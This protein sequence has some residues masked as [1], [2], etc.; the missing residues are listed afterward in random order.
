MYSTSPHTFVSA[1]TDAIRTL[2][3]QVLRLQHSQIM[4]IRSLLFITSARTFK[5]QV[6]ASTI[7]HTYVSGGTAA[8]FF[9]LTF[10]SGYNTNL[11]T[12]GMLSLMLHLSIDLHLLV[13]IPSLT[14]LVQHIL[15]LAVVH[16]TSR[17]DLNYQW[18]WSY[19]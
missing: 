16:L 11:G 9:P 17:P 10:G 8:Q 4:M 7:P 14:T 13:S 19:Y 12:I 6:G 18:S 1:A 3:Y 15:Q 5:V 2:N